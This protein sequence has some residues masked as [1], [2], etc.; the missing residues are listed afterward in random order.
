MFRISTYPRVS[1]TI[2]TF[3]Y[4]LCLPSVFYEIPQSTQCEFLYCH[5]IICMNVTRRAC[6][7]R[8]VKT[9]IIE[10]GN[11]TRKAERVVLTSTPSVLQ[12]PKRRQYSVAKTHHWHLR[13]NRFGLLY[14][15]Y[16]LL[17]LLLM[18]LYQLCF[19]SA[20]YVYSLNIY[21]R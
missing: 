17:L 18:L 20:I 16:F 10:I 14:Y 15:N 11:N 7:F 4:I 9:I 3:P 13:L 5:R 8:V 21:R 1:K 12:L 6:D 19:F 2:H